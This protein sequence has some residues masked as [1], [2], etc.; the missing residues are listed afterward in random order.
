MIYKILSIFAQIHPPIP[1]DPLGIT[2]GID[3]T[4]SKYSDVGG[5]VSRIVN[6]VLGFVG[7]I[8]FIMVILGGFW[9]LTA[10]GNDEQAAKGR[11]TVIY[12]I[13]GIIVILLSYAIVATFTSEFQTDNPIIGPGIIFCIP[14][15]TC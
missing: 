15:V 1:G 13:I 9:F 5:L 3:P 4:I 11:K 12:S 2:S 6:F 10:A 7:L 8:A 14:F